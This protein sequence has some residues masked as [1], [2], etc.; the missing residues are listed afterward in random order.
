VD[1]VIARLRAGRRAQIRALGGSMWPTVRDGAVL[2]VQPVD[3]KTISLGDLAAFEDSE[4]HLKVHRV[5]ARRPDHLVVKGD[6]LD[7]ADPP[8]PL[9]AVLGVA[10]VLWQRPFRPRLPSLRELRLLL[11]ALLRRRK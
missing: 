1:P 4:G 9:G 10:I 5:V 6:G 3:P 7:T 11:G 8:V 2:L